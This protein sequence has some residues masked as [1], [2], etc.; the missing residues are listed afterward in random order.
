VTNF[1]ARGQALLV[2]PVHALDPNPAAGS[3]ILHA[4]FDTHA[5]YVWNTLRRL[6]IP[7][8][9]LEDVTHDV[10]VQ[11]HRHIREYDPNRP[12]RPWLFAFAFRVAAQT[13]RQAHRR[14]ETPGDPDTVPHPGASPDDDLVA[15]ERRRL[16]IAALQS[17][18]LP[19][20]AVF[21]LHDVDETPVAE[22]ALALGIPVNTVYS[23][24]RVARSEFAEAV[25]RLQRRER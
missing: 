4:L 9:D 1:D 25:K 7:P 5:T 19:R 10:F 6:G 22:I 16:F 21:V 2:V 11:V 13:R 12:A 18:D 3:E 17:V 23:R 14:R 8:S 15:A 24:L 20:R